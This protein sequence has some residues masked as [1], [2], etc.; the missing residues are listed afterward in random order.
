MYCYGISTVEV[1][2]SKWMN[3]GCSTDCSEK[4]AEHFIWLVPLITTTGQ[5]ELNFNKRQGGTQ[6]ILQCRQCTL[7]EI[8]DSSSWDVSVH[9]KLPPKFSMHSMHGCG[10]KLN[11]PTCFSPSTSQDRFCSS[12]LELKFLVLWIEVWRNIKRVYFTLRTDFTVIQWHTCNMYKSYGKLSS[13]TDLAFLNSL[14]PVSRLVLACRRKKNI[15]LNQSFLNGLVFSHLETAAWLS[16]FQIIFLL[17]RLM[18]RMA[19]IH[20]YLNREMELQMY[21]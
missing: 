13:Q 3:F 7:L 16:Y 6:S 9:L 12:S 14:G 18:Q 19:T 17:I 8:S 15:P 21:L 10:K 2:I 4:S 11:A 1:K 5:K 20:I